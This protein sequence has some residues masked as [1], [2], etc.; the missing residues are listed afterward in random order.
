MGLYHVGGGRGLRPVILAHMYIYIYIYIFTY[1]DRDRDVERGREREGD[2]Q[3]Y[4]TLS[5]TIVV[6]L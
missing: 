5:T 6:Q 2:M 3:E 1:I 4:K